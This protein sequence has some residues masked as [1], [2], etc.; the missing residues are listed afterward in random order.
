M[1]DDDSIIDLFLKNPDRFKICEYFRI[2]NCRYGDSCKY[3]HPENY[4]IK[5]A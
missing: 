4:H 2:G 3:Q 5:R 1:S